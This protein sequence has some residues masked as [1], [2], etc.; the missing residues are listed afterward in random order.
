MNYRNRILIGD[1]L[2][3]LASLP[4]ESVHCV[5]TSPPYWGLRDYG[6]AGQIGLEPTIDEYLARMVAVFREV[7]RV[8]RRDGTLWLNMG[9][10]Y[11]GSWGAQGRQ[12]K[13]G[14]A[15]RSGCAARLIAAAAKRESGTGS[16]SQTPGLKAKDLVGQP[17]R[18]AL[19]LQADGW[20]LRSD[21]IWSKPNPMPS[22]VTDRPGV[23]HEYVFLLTKS[24]K[25]FYDA[26]AV[27]VPSKWPDHPRTLSVAPKAPGQPEHK[28]LRKQAMKAGTLQGSHGSMAHDGNGHR[29]AEV[30]NNP[31]GRNLRSVWTIPVGGFPGAHFAT[32]PPALVEPCIKAGTSQ[33]GVCAQCGAPWVREVEKTFIR[34]QD[35]SEERAY[36]RPGSL[37]PSSGW[38]GTPRGTTHTTTTGW[39][40]GCICATRETRPAVVLDPFLGSGTTALVALTM[41][42]DFVGIELNPEY[43]AMAQRRIDEK[44]DNLRLARMAMGA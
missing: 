2:D 32:F 6:V 26:E 25:Y 7:R 36:H 28:G 17:W 33:R 22:S 1:V 43:A 4:D 9:D 21:I 19:A 14:V 24:A 30:Y 41:G 13:S 15:G 12:G 20:W 3:M 37:D 23:A 39:R 42:R 29:Y 16:L 8:L 44:M 40:P 11:A 34:Q 10:S 5:V 31:A 38:A 35:V 27:R 18:L